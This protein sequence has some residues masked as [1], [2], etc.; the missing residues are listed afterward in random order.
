[1]IRYLATLG[2]ILSLT[3]ISSAQIA[4]PPGAVTHQGTGTTPSTTTTT[5]SKTKKMPSKSMSK[6]MKS[7]ASPKPKM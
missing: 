4:P 6:T 5:K 3:G 7:K 1:M 2:F